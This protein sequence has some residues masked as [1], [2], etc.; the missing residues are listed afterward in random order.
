LFDE[1][2]ELK[3]I[4]QLSVKSDLFN[5]TDEDR[6]YMKDLRITKLPTFPLQT[7]RQ[8][9]YSLVDLLFSYLFDL[10]ITD[11]EHNSVSN[12][13]IGKLSPSLSALVKFESAKQSLCAA[14]RRSLC[15]S[16]YRQFELAKLVSHDLLNLIKSGML[17]F[18]AL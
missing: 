12:A 18:V 14:I 5:L 8:I 6:T 4:K 1:P 3:S 9:S 17:S 2:D 15:H 16:L 7:Q 13:M 10:R 11:L